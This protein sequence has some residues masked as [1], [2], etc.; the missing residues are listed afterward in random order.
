MIDIIKTMK[1]ICEFIRKL[2][3]MQEIILTNRIGIEVYETISIV[4]HFNTYG[5]D[6]K[7]NIER[8]IDDNG[9]HG[10]I[11]LFEDYDTFIKTISRFKINKLS[12]DG[13]YNYKYQSGNKGFVRAIKVLGF[14]DAT[15][16]VIKNGSTAYLNNFMMY[17]GIIRIDGVDFAGKQQIESMKNAA[18]TLINNKL[19]YK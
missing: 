13:T 18:N 1:T 14:F 3:K 17:D 19:Y 2:F 11:K 15:D 16:Y 7:D 9:N 10:K 4:E 5:T 8:M 12:S 6:Y